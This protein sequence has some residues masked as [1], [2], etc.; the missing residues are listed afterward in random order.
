MWGVSKMLRITPRFGP[1]KQ[2]VE[3]RWNRQRTDLELSLDKHVT[4]PVGLV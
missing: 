1:Y 2:K 4:H 3:L